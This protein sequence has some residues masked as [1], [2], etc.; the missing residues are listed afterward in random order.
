MT[1][2]SGISAIW[3]IATGVII[4]LLY[5]GRTILAPFAL[6]VFLFLVIEGFARVI[7]ERSD[8]LKRGWSRAM[9]LFLVLGGFIGFIVL[10]ARG[11]TQF[12]G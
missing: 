8:L 4:A 3:I 5:L 6:A 9:A 12:G 1:V 7:D 2:K 10:L 11:V